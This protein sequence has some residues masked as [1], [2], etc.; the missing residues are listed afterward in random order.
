MAKLDT[1]IRLHRLALDEK[2]KALAAKEEIRARLL[3][4]R[5]RLKSQLVSEQGEAQVMEGGLSRG[6]YIKSTLKK[7][8]ILGDAIKTADEEIEKAGESLRLA[9]EE[10]KRYEIARDVRV[11]EEKAS[12]ARKETKLLDE[13]GAET[14]RRKSAEETNK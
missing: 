5:E 8:E 3:N 12:V 2:R 14:Y 4:E 9:F 11:E 6:Q 1:L 7:I 13:T 10:V